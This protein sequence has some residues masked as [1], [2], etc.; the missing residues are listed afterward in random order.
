VGKLILEIRNGSALQTVLLYVQVT[1]QISEWKPCE[2]R[3]WPCLKRCLEITQVVVT[4]EYQCLGKY[5]NY[6]SEI[7]RTFSSFT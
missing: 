4:E 3:N 7:T 6:K 2:K 5:T 1:L